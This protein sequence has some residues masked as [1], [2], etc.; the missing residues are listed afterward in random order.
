MR[1]LI[2]STLFAAAA[3]AGGASA[4]H[5]AMLR[6]SAQAVNTPE[7]RKL[8]SSKVE[9]AER[10]KSLLKSIHEQS[11]NRDLQ[12]GPSDTAPDSGFD[13]D[14]GNDFDLGSFGLCGG[15]DLEFFGTRCWCTLRSGDTEYDGLM[16]LIGDFS[17]IMDNGM[18]VE[19]G[20]EMPTVCDTAIGV[21]ECSAGQV[22][23]TMDIDTQDFMNSSFDC[24]TCVRYDNPPDAA[25]NPS[26]S[27]KGSMMAGKTLCMDVDMCPPPIVT[28]RS[29]ITD[30]D[31]GISNLLR[32]CS[33][34]LDDE[35][36]TCEICDDFRGG[37]KMECGTGA[38]KIAST[39]EETGLEFVDASDISTLTQVK[40]A[41]QFAIVQ[42]DA[43][44]DTSAGMAPGLAYSMYVAVLSLGALLISAIA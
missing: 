39:C 25:G 7:M 4:S 24:D 11:N 22:T 43:A 1:L 9:Q 35:D 26:D 38:D 37:V 10:L 8:L 15:E 3:A 36:C 34:K 14:F 13:F 6:A 30:L 16:D 44:E 18:E 20:C 12:N 21:N 40:F 29:G 42:S 5:D 2:A 17:D 31:L 23:C 33:A 19:F 32:G 28:E 27:A 41:P